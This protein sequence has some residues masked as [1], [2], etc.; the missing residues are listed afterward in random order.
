MERTLADLAALTGGAVRGDPAVRVRGACGLED[1]GPGDITFLAHPKYA[2]LVDRT[3]AG[4]IVVSEKAAKMSIPAIVVKDPNLAFIEIARQFAEPAPVPKGVHPSAVIDPSASLGKNV[5]VGAHSVI[6]A[7]AVI[8]DGTAVH[9]LVH[10]GPGA[11]VGRDSVLYSGVSIRERCV[12]G[13]RVIVH[14]GTVIGSDGFGFATVNG[15]HH[16]IP[17]SGIVVIEDDVELGANCT[18][19]RARTDKTVIRRGTKLDNLVHIGHNSIIGEHVLMAAMVAVAG[20]VKVEHHAMI[21]G[22]VAIGGHLTVGAG[23]ILTGQAGL[24]KDLPPGA[25]Y[26]GTPAEPHIARLRAL[27]ASHRVDGLLKEV[28]DLKNRIAKLEKKRAK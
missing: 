1:A 8:G 3:R 13:D 25:M 2:P 17:Q 24:S 10:V 23:G 16:K 26:S 27:A 21:G 7:G 18:I 9:P 12:L 14:C 15:V 20:S 5:G 19:D 6:D 4:A 28:R 11:R 22:Q